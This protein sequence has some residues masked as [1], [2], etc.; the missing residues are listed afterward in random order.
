MQLKT[1]LLF[2]CSLPHPYLHEYLLNS[3]L[4]LKHNVPS[5]YTIMCQVFKDIHTNILTVPNYN[6]ELSCARKHILNS[7]PNQLLN[8]K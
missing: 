1:I 8:E 5:I 6:D 7:T 4:P 2:L 3:T